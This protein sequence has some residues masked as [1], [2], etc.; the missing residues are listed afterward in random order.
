MKTI[1]HHANVVLF[2][3]IL[4]N[5]GVEIMGDT[6]TG[7]FREEDIPKDAAAEY[8]DCGLQYLSP[9]FIDLHLHGGG[10]ADF[11]DGDERA[12]KTV[13][14]VHARH[15]TTSFLPTT[16]SAS[17]EGVIKALR[18]IEKVQQERTA[19]PRILGAHLEGNF[20]SMRQKGAQDSAYIYPPRK[21]NY[22]PIVSAVG[23]IRMI[24][25]APETEGA[26]AFSELM[27]KRG[28]VMSVAH[29]DANYEQFMRGV[30]SGFSHVTHVYNGNSWLHSPYY[31]C[32]IG[33]CEA[34]LLEKDC[35][36]EVIAD[37]KHLPWQLLKLIYQIKGADRINLCT[38]AMCAACMPEGAG[39]KLGALDVVIEDGV[40]VLKDRSSFAGSVCTSDHAVRTMY[41]EA[42]VPLQDAVKMMSATPARILGEFDRIGSI[43]V[44][45]KADMVLFD[46]NI[47]IRD[48]WMDGARYL[49][50]DINV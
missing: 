15:G 35:Y 23:N 9:G 3:R 37:G 17:P 42:G 18:A 19:G 26:C 50:A 24:S 45:K 29:S 25:C 30:E 4:Y 2:D 27:K 43:A 34:A 33:V 32:Q 41:R 48:I 44:G 8:L 38:D 5:G 7:V 49:P 14:G 13:L 31:Y 11:M 20:I 16:L 12:V 36:V 10:G 40:A 28:I 1:L 22:E 47:N 46:E 39:Y 21:E 6:I